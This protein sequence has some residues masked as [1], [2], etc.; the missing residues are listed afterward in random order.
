MVDLYLPAFLVFSI[1]NMR[2]SDDDYYFIHALDNQNIVEF[3]ST[4]YQHW[5]SRLF[6]ELHHC[7]SSFIPNTMFYRIWTIL[8]CYVAPRFHYVA[9][10]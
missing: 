2:F 1:L 8:T 4:R 5:S 10:I 7:K 3:P 6:T 9:P